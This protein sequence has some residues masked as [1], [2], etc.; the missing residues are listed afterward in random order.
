MRNLTPIEEHSRACLRLKAARHI[1]SVGVIKALADALCL[2]RIPEHI[3]CDNDL[4]MIS[5]APGKWAA[6]AGAQIQYIAPGLRS[7]ALVARRSAART[8]HLPGWSVRQPMA[9]TMHQ[10]RN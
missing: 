5:K 3:R 8:C 6:K 9:A 10:P 4:Q 2:H 7:T 1:N